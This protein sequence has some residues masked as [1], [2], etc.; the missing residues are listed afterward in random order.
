MRVSLTLLCLA[1]FLVVLPSASGQNFT[2]VMAPFP[3]PAAI[4]PGGTDSSNLTLDSSGG[5]TGS[6]DLACQV[7]SAATNQ[8]VTSPACQVSPASRTPPGGA[9]VTITALGSTPTGRYIVTVTGTAPGTPS[10]PPVSVQQDLSV[11]PA[12][13]QFTITVK[14]AV[15]PTSIPAGN[16]A[17]AVININPIF[18]YSSPAGGVTLACSSI[19]PLVTI[20]PICSFSSQP[21][22]VPA[23]GATV[24]STLT[25]RTYGPVPAGAARSFFA[26]WL[27]LPM[28]AL[29]GLG[30]AAGGKQSRKAWG[31]LALFVVSGAFL[32]MPACGT[33]P[34]ATSTPN[35]ITP[36]NSYTFTIV[37]VD[38]AGQASSNTGSSG[39]GSA[40]TV[41]LSVT[42]PTAN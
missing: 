12:V 10:L 21:V 11:L 5:F 8:V 2:L 1:A 35:G 6:V 30:A 4:E 33:S 19:T 31:L 40:S 22:M 20:P 18:G 34:N 42:A 41:T 23:G 9:S 29:V 37:G 24:T 32:L 26:L 7:T 25:I 3:P 16:G 28:L 39:S 15:S 17:T 36:A 38:A 14:T 27:S 13:P